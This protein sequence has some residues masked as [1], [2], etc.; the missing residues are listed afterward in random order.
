MSDVPRQW[1]DGPALDCPEVSFPALVV[2]QALLRPDVVAVRQWD[3]RLTY[4]ELVGRAAALAAE[5]RGHGVGPEV[6]VAVCLPRVPEAVVAILG[7]MMAGGVH[8]PLEPDHPPLRLREIATDAGV[9]VA[10]GDAAVLGDAVVSVPV[11]TGR[12]AP[13]PGPAGPDDAAYVL[14]TSGSTG[15]PKGVVVTHRNLVG[16]LTGLAY[17]FGVGEDVVSV[18]FSSFGFDAFVGDLLLP[19]AVGGRAVLLGDADRADPARAERFVNAHGATWG[20]LTAALLPVLD[21]AAMPGWTSVLAGGEVMPPAEVARWAVDGR[22]FVNVYGPTETTVMVTCTEV[23]GTWNGP[24]P[25]GRPFPNTYAYVVDSALREVPVG[26]RGELLIG[27]VGVAR[28]YLGRPDLTAER[29]LDNPFGPGRVYRTGDLA[30]WRPDGMLAFHGRIDGQVKIRGQRL[31]LGEVEAVL[32]T[33][34]AV[35]QAVVLAAGGAL[36]AFVVS[37]TVDGL[38]EH[39]AERLPGYMVPGRIVPLDALPINAAGKQDLAAL[40]ALAASGPA[41]AGAASPRAAGGEVADPVGAAVLRAWCAVLDTAGAEP[42]DD[43]FG[44]GGH[45]IAAM[46]LAVRLRADLDRAVAVEDVFAGRTLAGLTSRVAVAPPTGTDLVPGSPPHLSPAQRRLWFLDHL[47]PDSTAY[48][49]PLAERLRGP[50]DADRLRSALTAVAARHEVLRWRIPDERGEPY[51]SVAPPQPVPLPRVDLAATE[52]AAALDAFAR[53]PFALAEGPLWRAKLFRLGPDDHVLAISLHH[54]VF[55]G[56]SQAPLYRD[57]A[58]FYSGQALDDAPAGYADYVAWRAERDRRRGP[59]DL[60]WWRE[61]LAGAP[62]TVDLPRTRRRPP[63]QTY[64]GAQAQATLDAATTARVR[65]LAG[66]WGSTPAMTLG[67]AF[68]YLLGRLTGAGEVV[69]GTPAADRRHAAF[70]DLVGFFVEVV[71]V[72]LRIDHAADFATAVRACRDAMLDALA[73]PAAPLERIVD[74]L[75]VRREPT[76]APLVQVLFNAYNFPEPRLALPGV[77]ASPVRVPMPGSPFDLTTYLVER[78]GR[79]AIDVLYNP[80]LYDPARIAVFLDSYV[81]LLEHVSADP[82]GPLGRVPVPEL[83]TVDDPAPAPGASTVDI[84]LRGPT[85]HAIADVWRGVLGVG[86]VGPEDNF[87]EIGGTSLA[88]V[89]VQLRLAEAL[90]RPLTVVDLFRFPNVRALAGYLD[91]GTDDAALA[92]AGQRAALRRQRRAGPVTRPPADPS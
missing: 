44:H 35:R 86:S 36:V 9:K 62:T 1:T 23:S 76:R 20:V 89:T 27:G 57:L 24:V 34:P 64:A 87:F 72:R 79:F 21:P 22:R 58:A 25:I 61:H 32:R 31:E 19:L 51:A 66:A 16:Y 84:A 2:A 77:D 78:D 73:H 10:V 30:S 28:G 40:Q 17:R 43:F 71:P 45:S 80:D 12:A 54:A 6:P 39:C 75:G 48:H 68:G 37:S 67:A 82:S 41:A 69:F 11:P 8:L 49:V 26:E 4:A 83:S 50:L 7:V 38:R 92:R 55:D 3:A 42:D 15:R 13:G 53:E 60:A 56:W 29:F 91:G 5:L 59:T 63:V 14:Y 52:L 70:A 81:Q 47:A 74:A 65:E 33:H 46:R 85:E 88:L 90:G 18:S